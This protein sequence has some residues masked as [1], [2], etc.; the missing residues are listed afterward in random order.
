MRGELSRLDVMIQ[1]ERNV[2]N[3]V[4]ALVD[5]PPPRP[6]VLVADFDGISGGDLFQLHQIRERGWT[7]V[8]VGIGLI[9]FP[10]RRSLGIERVIEVPAGEGA[11]AQ[12]IEAV[13][14]TGQTV[15]IP[16]G[17]D[18]TNTSAFQARAP[19]VRVAIKRR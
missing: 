2:A 16:I 6:A 12:Q 4:A 11:L 19:N 8:V 10:L 1:V 13:D 5:D 17:R 7:G 15:R 9:P 3:V 18:L 14:F